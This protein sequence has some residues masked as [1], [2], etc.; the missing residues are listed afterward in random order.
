MEAH[1]VSCF[2]CRFPDLASQRN[3]LSGCLGRASVPANLSTSL[4]LSLFASFYS[5]SVKGDEPTGQEP[6]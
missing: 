1:I 3:F 4:S 6:R 2:I 5:T